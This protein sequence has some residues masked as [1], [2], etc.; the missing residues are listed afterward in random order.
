MSAQLRLIRSRYKTMC[1]S[2]GVRARLQPAAPAIVGTVPEEDGPV[3]VST[4]RQ[5]RQGQGVRVGAQD[6]DAEASTEKKRRQ[7]RMVWALDGP[8]S[9]AS[10]ASTQ[11]LSF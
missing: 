8:S 2:L 10:S 9:A 5:A 7:K 4:S 6:P 11:G 3:P 1:A